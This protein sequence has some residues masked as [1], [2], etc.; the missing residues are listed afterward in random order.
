MFMLILLI[1]ILIFLM[2]VRRR[3][4]RNSL[5]A[6]RRQEYPLTL[7]LL[8]VPQPLRKKSTKQQERPKFWKF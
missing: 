7:S 8:F 4:W 2:C 3:H 6:E 1:L 5:K